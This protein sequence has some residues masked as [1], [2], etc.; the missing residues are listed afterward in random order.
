MW[1]RELQCEY[2]AIFNPAND[3]WAAIKVYRDGNEHYLDRGFATEEEAEAC[4][5][6]HMERDKQ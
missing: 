3:T 6:R 2:T 5:R 1:C 4:A